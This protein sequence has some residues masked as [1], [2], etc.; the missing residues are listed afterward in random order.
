LNM[1]NLCRLKRGYYKVDFEI[2]ANHGVM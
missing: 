1:D 2:F